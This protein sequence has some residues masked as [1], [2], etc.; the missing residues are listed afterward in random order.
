LAL[1]LSVT[2]SKFNTTG[3]NSSYWL[4]NMSLRTTQNLPKET[5][6]RTINSTF[7]RSAKRGHISLP[8]HPAE[9]YISAAL[10]A[11]FSTTGPFLSLLPSLLDWLVHSDTTLP[12]VSQKLLNRR[13][14]SNL[15]PLDINITRPCCALF[16]K[17]SKLR[18]SIKNYLI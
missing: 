13:H 8:P 4:V 12:H 16:V 9:R 14:C 6:N 1:R 18:K 2:L 15:T 17:K 11:V 7:S 5:G 10:S 3:S